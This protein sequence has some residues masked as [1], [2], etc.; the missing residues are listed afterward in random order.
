[1]IKTTLVSNGARLGTLSCH[2]FFSWVGGGGAT[3]VGIR[4]LQGIICAEDKS[5]TMGLIASMIA[6]TVCNGDDVL[7]L[8]NATQH[9]HL[10]S[11]LNDRIQ[12]SLQ[13]QVTRPQFSPPVPS[14]PWGAHNARSL[15]SERRKFV[16]TNTHEVVPADHLR[17]RDLELVEGEFLPN[18]GLRAVDEALECER[19]GPGVARSADGVPAARVELGGVLAPD[20][21][22]HVCHRWDYLE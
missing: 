6:I 14:S 8:G 4:L 21:G 15:H 5:W 17:Q 13:T 3:L 10:K 7:W 12:G 9:D 20:Q 2:H 22:V 11:L 16:L 19:L 1:M 18:A